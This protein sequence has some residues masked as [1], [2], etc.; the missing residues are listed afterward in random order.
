MRKSHWEDL[1]QDWQSGQA[2]DKRMTLLAILVGYD[3]SLRA[4]NLARGGKKAPDHTIRGQD[5]FFVSK[6]RTV[7]TIAQL[8]GSRATDYTSSTCWCS[9]VRLSATEHLKSIR[10]E[11]PPSERRSS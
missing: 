11:A 10:S 6:E 3:G 8:H 1:G 7:K 5:V 4:C 9:R 2:L